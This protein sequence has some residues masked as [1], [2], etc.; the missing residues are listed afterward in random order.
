MVIIPS[1]GVR[2]EMQPSICFYTAAGIDFD[3]MDKY[4]S[5]FC[6]ISNSSKRIR[7]LL[8]QAPQGML[9]LG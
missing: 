7:R 4:F 1:S 9:Q 8:W 6:N 5:D 3:H 2:A